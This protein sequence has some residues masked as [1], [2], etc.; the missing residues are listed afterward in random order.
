[1]VD[2]DGKL[3]G[4]YTEIVPWISLGSIW[5]SW[6]FGILEL[7]FYVFFS[8][9]HQGLLFCPPKNPGIYVLRKGLSLHSYYR[10]GIGTLIPIL[11]RGLDS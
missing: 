6:D 1:M 8:K 9:N 5:D 7:E 10:D 4:K 11:G 2:F 3:V